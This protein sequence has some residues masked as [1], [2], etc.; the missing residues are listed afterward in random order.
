M[1]HII[2]TVTRNSYLIVIVFRALRSTFRS[3]VTSILDLI[4]KSRGVNRMGAGASNGG[5][6]VWEKPCAQSS[7]ILHG[8][9]N[10]SSV[11]SSR[12]RGSWGRDLLPVRWPRA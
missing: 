7:I 10:A 11:G 6:L 4:T 12:T 3:D 8:G 5:Y 9:V 1:L 2:S